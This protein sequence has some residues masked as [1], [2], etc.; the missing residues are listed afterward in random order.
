MR[1]ATRLCEL[2]RICYGTVRGAER[3]KNVERSLE[4]SRTPDIIMLLTILNNE[5]QSDYVGDDQFDNSVVPQAVHMVLRVKQIKINVHPDFPKIFGSCVQVIW[6]YR[7]L[8]EVVEKV[9]TTAYDC[10]NQDHEMKLLR[11]WDLL[12][13]DQKLVSRVTKQWQDIGF[14]VRH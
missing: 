14:Q 2:Q 9:R 10:N 12:M 5:I 6:G 4:L 3:H 1:R 11:L 7:R 8:F 13:P